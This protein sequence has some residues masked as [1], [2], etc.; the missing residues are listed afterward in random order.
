[1][2]MK[3]EID[4]LEVTRSDIAQRMQDAKPAL[5]DGQTISAHVKNLKDILGKGTIMRSPSTPEVEI[6]PREKLYL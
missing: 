6:H 5:L 2:Q 3:A 4:S 1:M